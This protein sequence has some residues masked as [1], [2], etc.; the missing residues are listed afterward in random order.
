MTFTVDTNKKMIM[1]TSSVRYDEVVEL[2]RKF[3]NYTWLVPIE[4]MEE[5][6][7]LSLIEQPPYPVATRNND[8]RDYCCGGL[9]GASCVC[10]PRNEIC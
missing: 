10:D 3:P 6:Q 1:L 4:L 5:R 7:Q 2:R 9:G 8:P